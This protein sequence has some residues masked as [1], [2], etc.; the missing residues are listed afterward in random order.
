MLTYVWRSLTQHFFGQIISYVLTLILLMVHFV[1]IIKHSGKIYIS[2]KYLSI[3]IAFG[4][5]SFFFSIIDKGIVVSIMGFASLF[6]NLFVWKYSGLINDEDKMDGINTYLKWFLFAMFI[7]A[8]AGIYQY[9]IDASVF[10]LV[11][12]MYGNDTIM[13]ASNVTKRVVGFMGSPQSFSATCGVALFITPILDKKILRISLIFILIIVG[14]LSG[15]RAF[16]VFLILFAFF[17]TVKMNRK[18]RICIMF[19]V[20]GGAFLWGSEIITYI[21]SSDTLSRTL[22]FS[23]WAAF[24]VYFSGFDGFHWYNYLL[25]NGFGLKGWVSDLSKIL[26]DYSSTESCLISIVYQ[27]GIPAAIFYI[28]A[29]FKIFISS[30]ESLR[31]RCVLIGIFINIC[32]TPAFAGFAFSYVAW[33]IILLA[34]NYTNV[35]KNAVTQ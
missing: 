1:R 7:N 5:C 2:N 30:K 11:S 22:T 20:I 8:L 32:C 27:L 35:E 14:F 28:V 19:A 21:S 12:N 25:G 34:N 26:F 10:G 3:Y 24:K 33:P 4:V 17:V 6:L 9:F 16:G 29:Y 31:S 18:K 13:I 23:R 15:S